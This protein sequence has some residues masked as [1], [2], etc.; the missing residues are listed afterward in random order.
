MEPVPGARPVNPFAFGLN[1]KPF[2]TEPVAFTHD[3]LTVRGRLSTPASGDAQTPLPLVICSHGFGGNMGPAGGLETAF[4]DA[5]FAACSF[6]FCGGRGSTSDGATTMRSILTEAADLSAVLDGM[7]ARPDIDPA[8][9][10]LFGVS[11]G[12]M[13][14]TIVAARRPDDIRAL[15]MLFPAYCIHDDARSRV[16]ALG[17]PETMEVMGITLGRVYNTDALSFD[18]YD[19]MP[20][21]PGPVLIHHGTADTLVD[22]AY[23]RRAAMAFPHAELIEIEG[24][25]HG[26]RENWEIRVEA[27]RRT[28]AFFAANLAD[29]AAGAPAT[30]ELSPEQ[31]E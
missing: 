24:V 13:V 21:Y 2:A 20:S 16:E 23:S 18:V 19:L 8:R 12:G 6:D 28:A 15:A 17:N 1:P 22:I 25:G 10:F 14:S 11:E 26:F 9:I 30:A 31:A 5:G 3:G 7:R 29:E 4:T 27:G